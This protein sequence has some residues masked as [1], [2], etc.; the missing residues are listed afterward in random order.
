MLANEGLG[1]L[2]GAM[3]SPYDLIVIVYDN[4]SAVN[5]NIQASGLTT[6]GADNIQP[7]WLC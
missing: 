2:S 3:Q 4:E 5:T 7:Y 6:W 1:G